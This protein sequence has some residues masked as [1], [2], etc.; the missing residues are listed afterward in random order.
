MNPYDPPADVATP[1]HGWAKPARAAL[2][3]ACSIGSVWIVLS[4]TYY[5]IHFDGLR[6]VT[7]FNVV[8]TF[9]FVIWVLLHAGS[10]FGLALCAVGTYRRSRLQATIGCS[11]FA[12]ACLAAWLMR[13]DF[14]G[15]N[16]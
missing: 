6:L 5:F 4:S 13:M 2:S 8:Q 9:W 7:T 1:V 3:I 14:L 12:G 11:L 15:F 10:A 16:T